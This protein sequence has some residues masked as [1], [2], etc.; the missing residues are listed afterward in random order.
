MVVPA[1]LEGDFPTGSPLLCHFI[2]SY[3]CVLFE[4]WV[5]CLR[6]ILAS[7]CVILPFFQLL[8]LLDDL[9]SVTPVWLLYSAMLSPCTHQ[10]TSFKFC[11]IQ[12]RRHTK[13]WTKYRPTFYQNK[14]LLAS[15]LICNKSLIPIWNLVNL[16]KLLL[17]T[18]LSVF[19]FLSSDQHF[20]PSP[21]YSNLGLLSL[22]SPDFSKY[23]P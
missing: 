8:V 14:T 15:N 23:L 10:F 5:S 22:A 17:S 2:R 13:S 9:L 4:L 20:P 12:S 6:V 1:P 16:V 7:E 19:W 11:L 3:A 21:D 18:F